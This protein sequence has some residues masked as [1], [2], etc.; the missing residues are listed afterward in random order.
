MCGASKNKYEYQIIS[1]AKPPGYIRAMNIVAITPRTPAEAMGIQIGDELIS[2]NDRTISDV[3]DYEF[4]AADEDLKV[5]INRAGIDL[6]INISKGLDEELGIVVQ[7]MKM[8]SCANNCVF[9]FAHQNPPGVRE[10]LNFKDGDFR[11][12]FLHGHY[13]TMTNMG[14]RQLERVVEQHLSPLYISVHVTDP[15]L[16]RTMLLYG[17]DDNIL[18][19]LKFLTDGGIELHTQIVLCPGWNDGEI[20]LQTIRDLRELAPRIQSVSIV[21]VGLTKFRDNLPQLD[22]YTQETALDFIN[23]FEGRQAEFSVQGIDRFVYLSD[24][25]FILADKPIPDN[26][27]YG[28]FSMVEN[29]VGQCREF[30]NRF[31]ASL[32]MLPSKLKKPTRLVFPTGVLGYPFLSNTIGSTLD[33]VMNLEYEIIPIKNEWLGADLVTVTGLVP[34][35]DVVTQLKSVKADAIYLSYRMFSEDGITLDDHSREDIEKKLGI[36][37]YIHHEDMLE[38]LKPWM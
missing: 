11:F 3:I 21:P 9:C 28:E 2:I 17:K 36:P 19:K 37:V 6:R 33:A 29:G 30:E 10:A 24:E 18:D 32:P 35:R 31:R 27:Y 13:I 26:E 5:V 16:R 8:R 23:W 12:S 20:L 7:P 34:A 14:P 22:S 25:F 4:Y 1:S 15:E 38:I